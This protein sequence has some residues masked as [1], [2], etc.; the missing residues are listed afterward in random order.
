MEKF[1]HKTT[2]LNP[3]E[4]RKLYRS[5]FEDAA[6]LRELNS[7]KITCPLYFSPTFILLICFACILPLIGLVLALYIKIYFISHQ[8]RKKENDLVKSSRTNLANSIQIPIQNSS[9]RGRGLYAK[10]K[11]R[12]KQRSNNYLSDGGF[13]PSDSISNLYG[14]YNIYR[15]TSNHRDIYSNNDSSVEPIRDSRERHRSGDSKIISNNNNNNDRSRHTSDDTQ[16]STVIY[17][18]LKNHLTTNYGGC[19]TASNL[20]NNKTNQLI[21]SAITNQKSLSSKKR[22]QDHAGII[23]GSNRQCQERPKLRSYKTV[24]S[25]IYSSINLKNKNNSYESED[26]Y[27]LENETATTSISVSQNDGKRS[28]TSGNRRSSS[29]LK[30]TNSVFERISEN[31]KNAVFKPL[32]PIS[33][34]KDSTISSG[35]KQDHLP[36]LSCLVLFSKIDTSSCLVFV[37]SLE[38]TKVLLFS[39]TKLAKN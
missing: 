39:I 2:V 20:A 6:I 12:F 21:I 28:S 1:D 26:S 11:N 9:A 29:I 24:P 8:H 14:S 13:D 5:N 36:I 7:C 35:G 19:L 33:S 4:C 22:T 10:K 38:K 34:K 27:N 31:V 23:V 15:Y 3:V 25:N 32:S 17:P 30:N 37:L 18:K 16:V